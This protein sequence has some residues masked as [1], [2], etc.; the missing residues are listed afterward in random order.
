MENAAV[1]LAKAPAAEQNDEHT[2]VDGR[3]TISGK[4]ISEGTY[5]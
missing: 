1:N 2:D 3:F 5:G 4:P